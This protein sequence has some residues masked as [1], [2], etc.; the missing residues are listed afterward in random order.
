MKLVI[1]MNLPPRWVPW[2]QEQGYAAIHW[3][4]VGSPWASDLEILRWARENDHIVFTH[5][6]DF[7]RLLAMTHS[8]GPSV[9]QV[10]TEDVL[11]SAIGN[12]VVGVLRQHGDALRE[13]AI[14]VLEADSS[15]ARI[16]PI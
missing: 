3:S 5:D 14:V 15:R 10:R 12:L 13:G 6:L 8:S 11:P 1:D 9:F 4:E 2:L 7:S 16:L